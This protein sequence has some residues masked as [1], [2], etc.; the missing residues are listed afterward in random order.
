[1]EGGADV[2]KGN[3]TKTICKKQSDKKVNSNHITGSRRRGLPTSS[4]HSVIAAFFFFFN[5]EPASNSKENAP[6]QG[7]G[8]GGYCRLR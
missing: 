5:Y 3:I 2:L 1:M 4:P 8:E 7:A 6:A